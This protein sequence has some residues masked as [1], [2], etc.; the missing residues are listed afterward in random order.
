MW[1]SLNLVI[2]RKKKVQTNTT[3]KHNNKTISNNKEIA[4]CFNNYFQNAASNLCKAIPMTSMDPCSYMPKNMTNTIFLKPTND[5][6]ILQIIS[7]CK[8]A[9]AGFDNIDMK[10]IKSIKLN[11]I[12]P[13][14]HVCN[15]SFAQGKFPDDFKMA[16]IIPIHKKN[17][18][19]LFVNYRPISI[20]PAFSKIL[21]KLAYKRIM[22][23][24]DKN[25]ILY[26]F[27]F[28]FRKGLST[29]LAIQTLVEKYY[30]TI[31]RNEYM[32]GIFLDLSRAFDT[33]SHDILLRKLYNYG[34]RGIALDWIADYLNGRS[35][36]VS[37]NNCNSATLNTSIGI[38]QGSILGPLVFLLYVDD[39]NYVSP[40][41]SCIQF[42]DDTNIFS[43]G[44][45][46][47]DIFNV[48]N[49]ELES[50]S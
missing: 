23:F 16:K 12:T 35:Q 20:L 28:G 14:V 1:K 25:D 27:Q 19:Q 34:I 2:N 41:L 31:E 44:S 37:Y 5:N 38:P 29:D 40:N 36:Y 6:E 46:L 21:E 8:N 17:Y 39:L 22:D 43:T 48:L 15:L 9:S 10:I 33:I 13:L 7:T 4:S 32:V 45:S 3:F 49:C 24:L 18:K 11:I 26:K 50:I 47:D 30:D 42:A